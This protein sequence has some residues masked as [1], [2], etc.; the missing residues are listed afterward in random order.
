MP[1]ATHAS[2]VGGFADIP[3]IAGA[4][5]DDFTRTSPA[6]DESARTK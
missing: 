5:A 4:M 1:K 6:S 2:L 3:N